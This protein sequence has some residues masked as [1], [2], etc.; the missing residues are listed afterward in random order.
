M[1]PK[2]RTAVAAAAAAATTAN[3]LPP[4]PPT[5]KRRRRPVAKAAALERSSSTASHASTAS[6]IAPPAIKVEDWPAEFKA[7]EKVHRSLN[8]VF[9]FCCTRKH[10]ATTFENIKTSVEGLTNRP[11]TVEDI[12]QIKFFLPR[13]ISF[14]YVEQDKLAL[15]IADT[16]AQFPSKR[17][18]AREEAYSTLTEAAISNTLIADETHEAEVRPIQ[19]VLLFEYLDGDLKKTTTRV[20]K[21]KRVVKEAPEFTA[22]AMTKLIS[23]RNAKF[24]SAVSAFLVES[25]NLGVGPI[26]RLQ[27]EFKSHVPIEET[28]TQEP[29]PE[30]TKKPPPKLPSPD[31][32]PT[33]K[34]IIDGLIVRPSYQNQIVPNGRRTIPPRPPHHAPLSTPLS[35]SLANALYTTKSI[36]PSTF[37]SHQSEALNAI[38]RGESVVVGTPTSSG[39]SLIYQ[40]PTLHALEEDSGV[41]AMYIFPTKALAQDQ[42]RG[43]NELLSCT[44]GL[45]WVRTETFD[46]DTPVEERD[47]IRDEARVIFTNPDM[48]HMTILPNEGNWRMFLKGLRY[49]VVDELHIYNGIFGTHVAY[50]MRRLRRLCA[51]V[52]NRRVQ[53]ISCTATIQNPVEHM[54]HIFGLEEVTLVEEDGS[55]SGA[56]E[57][58]CWNPPYVDPADPS[59]GRVST[60]AEASKLF[61]HLVL[62]GIRVI[63]FCKIRKVCEVL[64]KTVRSIL[65]DMGRGEVAERVMSYRGGYTPQDRR[66]IE[67]EMF[68][69]RLVGII[70]TN[71][72]ELGV[73][74]GAL[75]AVICVGFPMTISALRQ[76]SGRAGRRNKDSLTVLVADPYPIDQHYMQNPDELFEKPNTAAQ[77]DLSNPMIL[78][79]H[80]QCAAFEMPIR[81]GEDESYFGDDLGMLADARMM[82][83]GEGFYHCHPRF[84]PYPSKHVAIRDVESDGFAVV[85][86]TNNRNVVLEEIEPT[87]A[88]F[89]IYEG[90]IFMHQ[91]YSYIVRE[92]N[93]DSK[94]A[95]VQL[96]NVDWITRPRDFTDVDP[97]ETQMIRRIRGSRSR[98][99]YGHI[100]VT[101]VVFGFFKLDRRN[102]ILD[103]VEV[104][105]PPIVIDTKGL[106][107]D[108]PKEALEILKM[109]H[110]NVAAAIHA[111]EHAVLSLLPSFVMSTPGE[112]RTECKDPTKELSKRETS[113]K[114]P[115][116]LIFY[117]ARGSGAGIS[118][119][120]FEFI[121]HLLHRAI[122]RVEVCNCQEGCPEC[123]ISS[124]CRGANIITSKAGAG[125]ILKK[126]LGRKVDID[127]L[128]EGDVMEHTIETVVES[129]RIPSARN[130]VVEDEE[131][132]EDVDVI[133]GLGEEITKEEEDEEKPQVVK[134]EEDME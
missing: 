83:D 64:V 31:D 120:A 70:A 3:G 90:A 77:V 102:N 4:D 18:R 2:K 45:E 84:K 118:L 10:L 105:N 96:A 58:V 43:M 62:R 87:R 115:A 35:Q 94:I 71:A 110:L 40:V 122:E 108:V 86:V 85:D 37:Y 131:S 19:N 55:P 14:N 116:R 79:G 32:R 100:R 109:K 78:E 99:F 13:S 121:D 25:Q 123:T 7:L 33:I 50:V 5:P 97:I 89:T 107:I 36:T 81:V 80:C 67:K 112:V 49:V 34:S 46:G 75:D 63:A 92:L 11:L 113:R 98:A 129:D 82:R 15:N 51:T 91:G 76:Q 134:K 106:W 68:E 1:P 124:Q 48:L 93:I 65:T 73:D 126:I 117:D 53:F 24:I 42:R 69:G 20:V 16:T 128:P 52:G 66:R 30:T 59:A 57:F 95:K 114:R 74:I 101:A 60:I 103:T 12:A 38:W 21:G 28:S 72:L 119:K 9:T 133:E 41:R 26:E 54:K 47:R 56:K 132:Q 130:V 22:A 127:T 88:I 111:A 61:I 125:V 44:E 39:K 6:S 104:D 17:A 23:K 27:A 29:Q 8:T